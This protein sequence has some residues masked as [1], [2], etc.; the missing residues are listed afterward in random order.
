MTAQ[1]EVGLQTNTVGL[2]EKATLFNGRL[3]VSQLQKVVL[4][5]FAQ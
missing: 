2:H 3:M 5:S 1:V 4:L